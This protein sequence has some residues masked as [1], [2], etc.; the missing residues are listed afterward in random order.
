MIRAMPPLTT[1][2]VFLLLLAL[3]AIVLIIVFRLIKKPVT[4]KEFIIPTKSSLSIHGNSAIYRSGNHNQTEEDLLFERLFDEHFGRFAQKAFYAKV[5]GTSHRNG[6]RTSRTVAIG[7]C[8]IF[9]ELALNHEPDNPHDSNAIKIIHKK[10]GA[11]LGYV[12]ARHAADIIAHCKRGG[13]YFAF[14]RRA[15]RHPET[16]RIVGAVYLLIRARTEKQV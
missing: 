13:S 3:T 9:D 14:F 2:P 15:T 11:Q 5:A 16:N 8:E 7:K 1:D 12:D 4:I 10:T 6:D